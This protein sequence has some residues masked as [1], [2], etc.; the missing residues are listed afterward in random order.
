MLSLQIIFVF[1]SAVGYISSVDFQ[2]CI[3]VLAHGLHVDTVTSFQLCEP[4][5]V[6]STEFV[7]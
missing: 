7:E 6:H 3:C 1:C 2:F 5:F 4:I